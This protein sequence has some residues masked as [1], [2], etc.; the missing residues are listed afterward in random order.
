MIPLNNYGL[1]CMSM[2]FL[3]NENDAFVWRGLMVM[4]AIGKLLRRVTWGPLDYLIVDM[5]PGTGDT[6][7]SISQNIPVSG[8][9][10]VTTPQD[11]ALSDARR[12]ITMFTKV[13]V[14]ILGIVENMSTFV[15]EKCGH[16]SN[17]FGSNGADKLV[18]ESNVDVLG[19]IPL[20]I[21]V[22]ET[23]DSGQ[24]IVVSHPTSQI[25]DVFRSIAKNIVSKLP[26]PLFVE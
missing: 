24:P 15:C 12:G 9:V 25:S 20:N 3:V 4:D 1:K 17:I 18:Q 2:G 7:L 10:I 11:I 26:P 13:N 5:P 14:P 19:R 22:R 16:E 23:C 21:K 8:A 6:Q